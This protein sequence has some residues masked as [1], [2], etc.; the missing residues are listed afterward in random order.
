[1]LNVNMNQMNSQTNRF[2]LQQQQHQQQQNLLQYQQQQL[3]QLNSI[4][5]P[6]LN[7]TTLI[8]SPLSTPKTAT[9]TANNN[10]FDD[11]NLKNVESLTSAVDVEITKL[12]NLQ[13]LNALRL[14]QSQTAQQQIPLLNELLQGYNNTLNQVIGSSLFTIYFQTNHD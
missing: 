8:S 12:Q 1:M 7:S 3:N 10:I 6:N 13:A 14:L 11:I 2:Q 9:T 5:Y 4:K